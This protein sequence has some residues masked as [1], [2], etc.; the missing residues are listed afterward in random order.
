MVLDPILLFLDECCF[1][2]IPIISKKSGYEYLSCDLH[3]L[4][5]VAPCLPEDFTLFIE[6]PGQVLTQIPQPVLEFVLERV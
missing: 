5:V 1:E 3:S 4:V 6:L 2:L